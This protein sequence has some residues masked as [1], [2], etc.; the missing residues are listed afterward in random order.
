MV[1]IANLFIICL[2]LISIHAVHGQSKKA[3]M[4]DTLDGKF[5]FSRFL[6][7]AHGFIPVPFIITEPA[8]G[9]FGGGFAP[10]FL[11]PKKG[12]PKDA[13]YVPPDI[14]AGFGMYTANGSWALGGMRIGTFPKA[15][16]KYRIGGGYADI[17][18]SFYRQT[19][20]TGEKEFA[21]NIRTVPVLASLSKKIGKTNL[22]A[23]MQYFFATM[24]LKPRFD[25]DL[26]DFITPREL[27]NNLASLGIFLEWDS[28][29]SVFTPDKGLRVNAL[30]SMN[31]NWTG[32]DFEFQRS[33]IFMN[34]FLP[35]K[36][37]W[38][39]G[40][41]FE[42]QHAFGDP[43]FYAL[44]IINMRGIPLGR[45][46]GQST[47]ILETEQRF[48]L[49]FR[50]SI[51]G[52]TGYGKTMFKDGSLA[53]GKNLYNVGGGFRYLIARAFKLRTGLDIA[54]GP[55]SWGWYLVFGHNWNR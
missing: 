37:N 49:N 43:P 7:D 36:K 38:I 26:P 22:Y 5:D 11:T 15:G 34:W 6:V 1:K 48:D 51:V 42:G 23:G 33:N 40:L 13:G 16:L 2:L 20:L 18:M 30:Y 4:K 10:L 46:Q 50:W 8:L 24:K 3:I 17:N 25:G 35:I 47:L 54:K 32:S 39:S 53:E 19:A 9:G 27:D 55:D 14:T 44:P 41:K 31:D 12:L 21:F 45:F 28:R 29:N 52:F